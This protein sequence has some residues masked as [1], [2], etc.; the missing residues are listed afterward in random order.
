MDDKTAMEKR[1]SRQSSLPRYQIYQDHRT[2]KRSS[3]LPES[4]RSRLCRSIITYVSAI[5]LVFLVIAYG[6]P[7]IFPKQDLRPIAITPASPPRLSSSN[8]T[9]LVPL[10]A[11]VMSKCPDARDCLRDLVVPA[12]EQVNDKV[13]FRLSYIGEV[14]GNGTI[15]CMHGPTECLGNMLGL[16]ATDLFPNNTKIS[17]GF[18]TC[19]VM[20]YQRIPNRDL[21]QSCALEHSVSFDDLNACISEEG[22]GL[23]M[24]EASVT[25]SEKAG[26][27]KSCTVRVG[28]EHWC[29]RD[30]GKWKDC[31]G[32]FEVKDLVNEVNRRHN[33]T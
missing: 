11:H 31:E 16:C 14:D 28:G 9:S 24:L 13:D 30:G 18:T 6:V 33:S 26:V 2:S 23:D 5:L 25:R 4:L 22:N 3:M 15:H 1:Y 20:S 17:L 32:G 7:T 12:M 21:V 27:K 29:L 8:Q 10:E 19:L